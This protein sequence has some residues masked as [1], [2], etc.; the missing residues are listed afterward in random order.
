VWQRLISKRRGRPP[1]ERTATLLA[2]TTTPE[3]HRYW[4]HEYLP[5]EEARFNRIRGADDTPRESAL[6]MYRCVVKLDAKERGETLSFD[7][8]ASV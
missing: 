8:L 2:R 6:S 3:F 5:Q 1:D 7:E 4:K